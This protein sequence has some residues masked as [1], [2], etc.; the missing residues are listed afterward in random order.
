M[1][2]PAMQFGLFTAPQWPAGAS[3]ASAI[4]DLDAQ[5]RMARDSGFSSVF[6]GQ[7]VVTAPMQSNA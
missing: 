3:L 7:H 5:V 6:I 1:D 4:D 2:S